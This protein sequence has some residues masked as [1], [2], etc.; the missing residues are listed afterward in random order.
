[1]RSLPGWSDGEQDERELKEIAHLYFSEKK[2]KGPPDTIDSGASLTSPSKTQA[3]P[4]LIHCVEEPEMPGLSLFFLSN[5]AVL[6]QIWGVPV[7][8]VGS[9]TV[10]KGSLFRHMSGI[11]SLSWDM[12]LNQRVEKFYGPLGI[13]IHGVRDVLGEKRSTTDPCLSGQVDEVLSHPFRHNGAGFVFVDHR[14][15]F[16]HNAISPSLVIFPVHPNSNEESFRDVSSL[17]K[18]MEQRSHTCWGIIVLGLSNQEEAKTLYKQRADR[19][20]EVFRRPVMDC[21]FLPG[22]L[23]KEVD[24]TVWSPYVLREPLT[25]LT[26]CVKGIASILYREKDTIF[27]IQPAS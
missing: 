23:S 6:L 13:P 3:I 15:W 21:G 25:Y 20:R 2:V 19:I 5:V 18:R 11:P 8:L 26:Q 1:M 27:Q 24:S 4:L 16:F 17:E 9:F 7:M 12:H 22:D 14:E 10:L